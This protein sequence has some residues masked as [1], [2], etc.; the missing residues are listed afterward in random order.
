M[1]QNLSLPVL[2]NFLPLLIRTKSFTEEKSKLG[3][4]HN[5]RDKTDYTSLYLLMC[6]F[7]FPPSRFQ[8][9]LERGKD[10]PWHR[11]VWPPSAEVSWQPAEALFILEGF[12]LGKDWVF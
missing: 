3:L 2:P 1:R 4:G 12:H 11:S 7:F 9:I 5:H 10:K 6:G 8:H